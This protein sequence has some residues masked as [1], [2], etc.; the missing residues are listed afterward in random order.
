MRKQKLLTLIVVGFALMFFCFA[1]AIVAGPGPNTGVPAGLK[2]MGPSLQGIIVA[3]WKP[4]GYNFPGTPYEAGRLEA[5]LYIEN[6]LYRGIMATEHPEGTD[7][8]ASPDSGFLS[9]VPAD[10]TE[11]NLP[12][13]IAIDNNISD[14]HSVKILEE[15][16]VSNLD[17]MFDL[18][19]F[20][21][22]GGYRHMLHC[23]VKVSI[24]VVKKPKTE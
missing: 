8:P 2:V 7:D 12:L 23:K 16:D 5:F 18:D 21:E 14:P 15:R 20:N 13:Q 19:E 1:G 10:M 4:L 11:W 6:K 3:G 9:V 24:L 17:T 22:V